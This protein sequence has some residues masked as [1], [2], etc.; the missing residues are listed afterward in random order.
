ML[1]SYLVRNSRSFSTLGMPTAAVV[2]PG[3]C[4]IPEEWVSLPL[5]KTTKITQDVR[6]FKFAT[7]HPAEPLNLSTCSCVLAS[8]LSKT[9]GELIV[10]PYTPISTN[11]LLGSFDLMVKIYPDGEMSQRMSQLQPGDLLDFKH[12]PFNVK[13]QY[14]FQKRRI[15]M[16]AGGTGLTPMIQALHAILGTPGDETKVELIYGAKTK[17]DLINLVDWEK[18]SNGR[19]KVHPVLSDEPHDSEWSG[20][21]GF[22]DEDLLFRIF[23]SE[24]KICP[25]DDD[26]SIWVCGPKG[27]L[28][29]LCGPRTETE[30]QEGTV[31]ANMGYNDG[32]IYKF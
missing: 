6:V 10:R 32:Q 30:L 13:Q 20:D 11:E 5:I 19:L 22:I 8:T 9:S 17:E 26:A 7:P 21:R 2:P 24:A 18:R 14:P 1:R 4:C 27:M 16:I 25:E 15:G 3:M 31:L 28:D 29:S 12:I 23:Q